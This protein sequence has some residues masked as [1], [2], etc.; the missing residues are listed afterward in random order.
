V[1][2]NKG[3]EWKM[4]ERIGKPGG[5]KEDISWMICQQGLHWS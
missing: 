2:E 4:N 3:E 1:L 5:V